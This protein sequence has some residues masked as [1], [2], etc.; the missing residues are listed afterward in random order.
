MFSTGGMRF[1]VEAMQEYGTFYRRERSWRSFRTACRGRPRKRTPVFGLDR[2]WPVRPTRPPKPDRKRGRVPHA[3][4]AK[5]GLDNSSRRHDTRLGR[6]DI[7]ISQRPRGRY[8]DVLPPRL[9]PGSWRPERS[10]PWLD[11]GGRRRRRGSR[12]RGWQAG[13]AMKSRR[14]RLFRWRDRR[15]RRNRFGEQKRP[16]RAFRS[17]LP[18]G[19]EARFER[20]A[21]DER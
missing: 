16:C 10:A 21:Y 20:R 3:L 19:L 13:V 14:V 8:I 15:P 1:H 18:G 5:S 4:L 12:R 2:T 9:Y 11:G 7:T 6:F 17:N